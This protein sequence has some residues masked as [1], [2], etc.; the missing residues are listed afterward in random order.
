MK[1]THISFQKKQ[2]Q[3]FALVEII[4]GSAIISLVVLSTSLFFQKTIEIS[5]MIEHRIAAD[6]SNEVGV[7]LAKDMRFAS[8]WSYTSVGGETSL[9]DDPLL[10]TPH[11]WVW[12][13]GMFALFTYHVQGP[14]RTVMSERVYR[15]PVTYDIVTSGGV[16]DVNT[17]KITV[18]TE[19]A[20]KTGS[21]TRSVS[22]YITNLY[23]RY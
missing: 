9:G 12:N 6:Y 5:R 4:I 17:R 11:Y 10:G 23:D 16:E 21:S 8:A 2:E 1:F 18:T 15:D 22:F 3:G 7:E 19:W 13:G 20:E 14:W